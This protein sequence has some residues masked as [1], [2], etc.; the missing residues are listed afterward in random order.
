MKKLILIAAMGATALTSLAGTAS[1]QET[2]AVTKYEYLRDNGVDTHGLTFGLS[3]QYDS[4]FAYDMELMSADTNGTGMIGASVELGYRFGGIAGPVALYETSKVGGLH[5]D[6][7]L[8]GVEGGT[9][10]MG[11][12]VFGKALF[13][14][15]DADVY[16]LAIGAD[17]AISDALA[18]NGELTHFQN[19]GAADANLLEIG[20]R[21]KLTGNMHAD[22]G[23]H[24]ERASGGAEKTGLHMGVGFSF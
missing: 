2:Y 7:F 8:I 3:G 18:V 14:A 24:Y 6:Q 12:G 19:V 11:A 4:G 10:L 15:D 22:V 13:D 17:F 16:R 23:A 9:D 20:A 5:A 21:Y 1:A